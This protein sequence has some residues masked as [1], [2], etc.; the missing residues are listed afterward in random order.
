MPSAVK[1]AT[2]AA[3]SSTTTLTWSNLLIPEPRQ[4][5]DVFPREALCVIDVDLADPAPAH[6]VADI[7]R[8][9]ATE[10]QHLAEPAVLH[11]KGLRRHEA[12]TADVT[13]E[14]SSFALHGADKSHHD[15]TLVR[16]NPQA[17]VPSAV[18]AGVLLT[19]DRSRI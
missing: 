7:L 3:R 6:E 11:R 15:G 16:G 13:G 19:S 17:G 5:A 2:A 8:P 14:R 18:L 9:G 12:L 4:K 1:K 10:Y